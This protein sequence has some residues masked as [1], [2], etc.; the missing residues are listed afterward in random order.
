[1]ENTHR[2]TLLVVDDEEGPRQSL[3]FVFQHDYHV[4]L[5]SGYEEAMAHARK[6]R[7]D[8][9]ILDIRMAGRSGIEVLQMLKEIDA[10]IEVI[11][12]TA[13]ETLGTAR[14]ALRL[15]ARDYIGKPFDVETLQQAV[16][17]A[18]IHNR[19]SRKIKEADKQL[20]QIEDQLLEARSKEDMARNMNQ[21][22]AGILHDINNP[23]SVIQ[24]FVDLLLEKLNLATTLGEEQVVE[25][26]EKVATISRQINILTDIATRHLDFLRRPSGGPQTVTLVNQ[27][28]E[29]LREL[30][31][32]HPLIRKGEITVTAL[33]RDRCL[34]INPAELMQV[35]LNLV[36]NA[37][38]QPLSKKTIAVEARYLDSVN[39][40]G[41]RSQRGLLLHDDV[42]PSE[43]PAVAISVKD[44]A[45]GIPATVLPRIFEAHFSA[46]EK[47]KGSGL[48]LSIVSA[49]VRNSRGAVHVHTVE[50]QGSTFTILLPSVEHREAGEEAS[51]PA[52][53]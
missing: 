39:L 2:K 13:Y 14:Q 52:A 50:G 7:I 4:L 16:S 1:M 27:V 17:K 49:I 48:G 33:D 21:L 8:V 34:P 51:S 20:N 11:M 26:R 38:L 44:Q 29:D 41:L 10:S 12:L 35:M 19:I 32:V 43:S 28:L 25:M 53:S 22:Y 47:Q 6:S 42:F 9:A 23:L 3:R 36:I 18:F 46:R 40:E 37:I 5:A 15:G 31:N 30:V 45:G 24:C